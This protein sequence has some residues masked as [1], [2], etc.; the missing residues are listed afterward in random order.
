MDNAA[1]P[2]LSAWDIPLE[3]AECETCHWC[4]LVPAGRPTG[5]CPNCHRQNLV[6]LP[7]E[8]ANLQHLYPPELVLP[9]SLSDQDLEATTK[10]FAKGIPFPPE[11]LKAAALK[12]RM[13]PVYLPIWLVDSCTVAAWEAEAGFN[14]EVISHQENYDQDRGGW[15]SK[16][17]REGRT[18]WEARAGKLNR[19]YQNIPSPALDAATRLEKELGGFARV[20]AEPYRPELIGSAAIRLPEQTPDE[21]WSEAAAAIQ[22]AATDECRQACGADQI[23]AFRWKA[24]FADLNWSLLLLPVY[25]SY[26]LDDRDNPQPVIIHGQ[27]GA[28]TGARRASVK[29]AQGASLIILLVGIILLLLGLLLEMFAR[30]APG[31]HGNALLL[32]VAGIIGVVATLVPIGMAWEFN[33]RQ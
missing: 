28:I 24:Q 11:E 4:Y 19:T 22:R 8:R 23:R 13:T 25:T 3:F 32:E 6:R 1:I 30:G 5:L 15:D 27:T 12:A 17:V 31:A 29:R 7:L 26:Y 20:T 16:E 21:T 18:R 14:Y 2:D 9:F 33:R 10:D